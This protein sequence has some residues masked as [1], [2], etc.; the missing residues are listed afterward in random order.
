MNTTP[1]VD[2]IDAHH[3]QQLSALLDDELGTD[4]A[5]FLVR[6]LQHDPELQACHERW[7]LLGD[8][9]RGQVV[10]PAPTG[11]ADRVSAAIAAEPAPQVAP[12]TPLRRGGWRAW[13][14][15]ALAA[16]VAALA[17]FMGRQ[18]LAPEESQAD[19]SPQVI[20]SEAELSLPPA[21]AS[22]VTAPVAGPADVLV[23][24]AP[25]VAVAAAARRPDSTSRSG[26]A[27]RTQQAARATQRSADPQRRIA[28]QLP[29]TPTVPAT[30]RGE[31]P[32]GDVGALQ[33]KPWPRA[34][35]APSIETGTF[36]ARL[37]ATEPATF[38][39]FEPRLQ[40]IPQ[41]SGPRD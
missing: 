16:S 38:Y 26:S 2:K 5:R 25:A 6:R 32:F 35:L 20:A 10:T 36:N 41:A 3:R 18:G 17:L 24:A 8:V 19:A 27:T 23:G 40:E 12:A 31:L 7:S 15:G 39:P 22:P 28:G 4:E 29:L 1:V 9:L 34:A 13:G 30:H 33:A 37:P 21:V 14:G 11:F